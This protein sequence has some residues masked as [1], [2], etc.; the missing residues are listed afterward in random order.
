MDEGDDSERFFLPDGVAVSEAWLMGKGG[1]DEDEGDD[2]QR[3]ASRPDRLPA[4]VRA[5][6]KRVL[7][8]FKAEEAE[9]EGSGTEPCTRS[10]AKPA[11]T[12]TR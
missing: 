7:P 6:L 1:D 10:R 8:G 2:E 4:A 12:T 5:T 9:E 3:E 11:S